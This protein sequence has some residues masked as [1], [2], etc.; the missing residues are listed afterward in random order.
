MGQLTKVEVEALF[1]LLVFLFI[2]F[3]SPCLGCC[4]SA[5]TKVAKAL[6]G[7]AGLL[8]LVWCDFLLEI[9]VEAPPSPEV[10]MGSAI[11]HQLACL[12]YL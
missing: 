12:G 7:T 1:P 6:R 8:T 9:A 4:S 3:S 10:S 5:E 2:L 11:G